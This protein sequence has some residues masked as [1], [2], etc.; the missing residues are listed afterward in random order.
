[1]RGINKVLVAG[2][3]GRNISFDTTDTTKEAACSFRV[4]SDR[5]RGDN[6]VTAWVRVNVYGEGLVGLVR[7]RIER[8]S[9][10]LIDGELMN[11]RTKT[12]VYTELR[13]RDIVV[14]E[15]PAQ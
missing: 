11:R 7:D 15:L 12:G 8:G 4:F 14:F 10:V 1:M 2:N 9:Y 6:L 13:A 5:G 3:V